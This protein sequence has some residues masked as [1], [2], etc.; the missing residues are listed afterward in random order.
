VCTQSTGSGGAALLTLLEERHL[1]SK[2]TDRAAFTAL[3]DAARSPGRPT[4][5]AYL[6]F[7]PT[8]PSLHVG[9][10][11]GL[12]VLRHVRAAGVPVVAL[13]GGITA[14]IGDPS[15]RATD[16]EAMTA[17]AVRCNAEQLQG[18]LH[19]LLA[20]DAAEGSAELEVM[21]N[22]DWL[23]KLT[24]P[25]LLAG[26]GRH[27]RIG[28]M[29]GKD[30]VRTR[31]TPP[32]EGGDAIGM[33]F[34]EFAYPLLQGYDWAEL[35]ARR[36]CLLQLGGSD[37]WGNITDG[38]ELVRRLQQRHAVGLTTPLLVDSK[39]GKLGKSAGNA[40]WLDP[41]R[42]SPFELYQFF[43]RFDGATASTLLRQLTE[44]PLAE[45]N[46]LTVQQERRPED[47]AASRKLAHEVVHWVHGLNGLASAIEATETLYGGRDE[48]GRIDGEITAE[49]M[50]ASGASITRLSLAKLTNKGS[51]DQPLV[52]VLDLCL[53]AGLVGSKTEV[54]RLIKAGGLYLDGGRVTSIVLALD[55]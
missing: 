27:L 55:W 29:L 53:E 25:E 50:A 48:I 23:G 34:S 9:H 42:T 30:N 19:R 4:P 3:V 24:V 37:Q 22:A 46:Q 33:S 11:L 43:R 49:I 6:G 26:A 16:R 44:V 52:S 31:L 20:V 5:R 7:D 1:L 28:A 21:D 38:V 8:A 40:V 14:L 45:I 54:R 18:M 32:P 51:D 36:D 10:L 41:D 39:G 35:V 47:P 2:C 17:D 15:G 13:V 12:R